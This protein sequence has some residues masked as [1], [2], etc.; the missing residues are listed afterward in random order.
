M[1]SECHVESKTL[2]VG[3]IVKVD[4]KDYRKTKWACVIAKVVS[5]QTIFVAKNIVTGEALLLRSRDM[6]CFPCKFSLVHEP[7]V[8][9]PP[10]PDGELRA[11]VLTEH[12]RVKEVGLAH[13][14]HVIERVTTDTNT[15]VFLTH[16][17]DQPTT[18]RPERLPYNN[19]NLREPDS[20]LRVSRD[21]G[22]ITVGKMALVHCKIDELD[23]WWLAKVVSVGAETVTVTLSK[24]TIKGA[25]NISVFR[26]DDVLAVL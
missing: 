7:N 11:V 18:I 21:P 4:S 22:Q 3:R 9:V 19:L 8:T 26:K 14:V 25:R 20:V 1:S 10:P 13:F 2:D 15:I 17:Q 24:G 16:E 6:T 12:D 5:A 23:G